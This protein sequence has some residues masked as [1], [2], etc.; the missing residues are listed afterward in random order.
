[1][2]RRTNRTPEKAAEAEESLA[3]DWSLPFLRTLAATGNVTA[4]CAAAGIGRRTAYDR[5]DIDPEFAA[6]WQEA[7]EAGTDELERVARDRA[8]AGSDTLMIFLLKARRPDVYRE[9][10]EQRHSG[11][12]TIRL[13]YAD[14]ALG[15]APSAPPGPA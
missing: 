14:D 10:M 15:P 7:L 6:A 4:S 2:A 3:P 12:L 13:E 5:K 9:S 1:M 11:G 8:L